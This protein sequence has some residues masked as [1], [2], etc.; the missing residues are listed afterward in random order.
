MS[1]LRMVQVLGLEVP[2]ARLLDRYHLLEMQAPLVQNPTNASQTVNPTVNARGYGGVNMNLRGYGDVFEHYA[3]GAGFISE[4][5]D[6]DSENDAI[7]IFSGISTA[8][9]GDESDHSDSAQSDCE[10]ASI[11]CP[12]DGSVLKEDDATVSGSQPVGNT[13]SLPV[14]GDSGVAI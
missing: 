3:E 5:D 7:S 8:S 4:S 6:V 9:G 14:S 2:S 12:A 1:S 11:P 13:S 10:A